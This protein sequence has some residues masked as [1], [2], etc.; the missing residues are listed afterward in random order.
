MWCRC[1]LSPV[2]CTYV[3]LRAP[4]VSLG[5]DKNHPTAEGYADVAN[6]TIDAIRNK[7][8]TL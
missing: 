6:R 3:D 2:P 4:P 8:I 1:K 5:P 7:N